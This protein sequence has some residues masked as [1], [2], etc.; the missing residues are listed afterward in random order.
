LPLA[1]LR[2]PTETPPTAG[3]SAAVE[4]TMAAPA[5]GHTGVAARR[6]EAIPIAASGSGRSTAV[7]D[8]PGGTVTS[9]PVLTD[10][11]GGA[12]AAGVATNSDTTNDTAAAA[13]ARPRQPVRRTGDQIHP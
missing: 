4:F 7:V 6:A 8:G 9:S 10:G 3:R 2:A 12:A 11:P 5:P 1:D 13:A